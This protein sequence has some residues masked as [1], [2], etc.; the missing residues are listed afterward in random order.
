[1]GT[2]ATQGGGPRRPRPN[3]TTPQRPTI[4]G[5]SR[6]QIISCDSA[7]T[8][9]SGQPPLAPADRHGAVNVRT[10]SGAKNC[11][12]YHISDKPFRNR[13]RTFW[14][15][16]DVR[17]P[18]SPSTASS[19]A[20]SGQRLRLPT[21]NKTKNFVT[22]INDTFLSWCYPTCASASKTERKCAVE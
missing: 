8:R 3:L 17:D 13:R 2:L 4:G 12:I 7:M 21:A 19:L 15:S 1:M 20:L 9:S 16:R 22:F 5:G 6:P 10:F 18:P 11:D 14:S